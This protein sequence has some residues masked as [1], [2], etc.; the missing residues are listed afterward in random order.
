MNSF[1]CDRC[2]RSQGVTPKAPPDSGGASW[3][4]DACGHY[5]IGSMYPAF[6]DSAFWDAVKIDA[7]MA[8][9]EK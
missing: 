3:M 7:A 6:R 8:G 4:C 1:V 5:N 9:G 2:A